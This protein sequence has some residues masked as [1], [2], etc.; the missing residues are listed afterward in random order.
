MPFNA[1][2]EAPATAGALLKDEIAELNAVQETDGFVPYFDW[3]SPTMLD[4]MGAQTQLLLAGRVT[5]DQLVQACQ[6]D[7]DAFR[8]TQGK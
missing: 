5:P 8:K 7:Y 4:T 2:F 1:S 6:K 3:A